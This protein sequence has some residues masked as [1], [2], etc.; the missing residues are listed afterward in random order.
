MIY[1]LS[2]QVLPG[3]LVAFPRRQG[4]LLE[5]LYYRLFTLNVLADSFAYNPMERAMA[6]S[7]GKALDSIFQLIIKSD[8][9]DHSEHCLG[10]HRMDETGIN[11]L[12]ARRMMS[13]F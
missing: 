12:F 1:L 3:F 10:Q 13:L 8:R 9:N 6:G 2:C 5:L 4:F 11:N 7:T